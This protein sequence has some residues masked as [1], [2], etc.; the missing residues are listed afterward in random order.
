MCIR[1][2]NFSQEE[3]LVEGMTTSSLIDGTTSLTSI[4]LN[5]L[6]EI[7]PNPANEL[8]FIAAKDIEIESVRIF[9]ATGELKNN[10]FTNGGVLEFSTK[11]LPN[12]IYFVEIQTEEGRVTKRL[13]VMN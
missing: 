3:I 6:I 12:G 11:E 2:S 8:F 9:S 13:S 10:T 7:Y 4:E 1:D 5:Q